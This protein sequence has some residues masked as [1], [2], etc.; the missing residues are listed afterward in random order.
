[1]TFVFAVTARSMTAGETVILRHCGLRCEDVLA[2]DA[3]HPIEF[4]R[5]HLGENL[6]LI[7]GGVVDQDRGVAEQ[8]PGLRHRGAQGVDVQEVAWHE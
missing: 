7:V 1:M 8:C 3:D 2:V 4:S 5:R 6:T